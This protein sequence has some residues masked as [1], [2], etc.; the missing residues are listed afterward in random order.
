M[1]AGKWYEQHTTSLF[2]TF[3]A[4][5][6]QTPKLSLKL[7]QCAFNPEVPTV[8]LSQRAKMEPALNEL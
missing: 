3:D 6:I 7:L 2:M 5:S 1:Q 4:L 8:T